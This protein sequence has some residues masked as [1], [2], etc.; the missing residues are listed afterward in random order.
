[1]TLAHRPTNPNPKPQD[2]CKASCKN[3][4]WE[5]IM[6]KNGIKNIR[7]MQTDQTMQ[8]PCEQW[9][10]LSSSA[11]QDA[12]RREWTAMQAAAGAA[13]KTKSKPT[14]QVVVSVEV[15]SKDLSFDLL[16]ALLQD[17][18][19]HI[20]PRATIKSISFF[21]PK[22]TWNVCLNNKSQIYRNYI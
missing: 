1:M 3:E 9:D 14:W 13:V 17:P 20:E 16:F 2:S 4:W 22:Y 11:T 6:A 12:T 21:F 5:H 7:K 15:A 8:W 10:S 18:C 19:R